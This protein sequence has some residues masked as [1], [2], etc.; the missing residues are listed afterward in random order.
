MPIN[1][2]E[3]KEKIEKFNGHPAWLALDKLTGGI[4]RHRNEID[5]YG[6]AKQILIIT[7]AWEG[8]VGEHEKQIFENSIGYWDEINLNI[9]KIP[10]AEDNR[11]KIIEKVNILWE[12]LI[13]RNIDGDCHVFF[14]KFLHWHAPNT[15]SIADSKSRKT[16][17]SLELYQPEDEVSSLENYKRIIKAYVKLIEKLENEHPNEHPNILTQLINYDYQTQMNYPL[18]QRG[19]TILRVLDK[20][21]WLKGKTLR[22]RENE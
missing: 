14:S 7:R 9:I 13:F 1:I 2:E 6:I 11:K 8:R 12:D 4:F 17:Q 19:N 18:L 3:I 20:W 15:F 5:A 22:R 10:L 21:L 16:L